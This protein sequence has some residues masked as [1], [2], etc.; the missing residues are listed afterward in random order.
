[1]LSD[2]LIAVNNFP[3]LQSEKNNNNEYEGSYAKHDWNKY[4]NPIGSINTIGFHIAKLNASELTT[5]P[6]STFFIVILRASLKAHDCSATYDICK[7]YY[8][9]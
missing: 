5:T 3:V 8:N 6:V 4:D 7:I 1:M 2:K 9:F